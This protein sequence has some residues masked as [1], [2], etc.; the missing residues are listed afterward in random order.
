MPIDMSESRLPGIGTKYLLRPADGGEVTLILHIDGR[1]EL[2]LS[3][4]G[5]SGTRVSL[6][7]EESRQLGAALGGAWERPRIV[8]ELELALGELLIEWTAVPDSSPL[9]GYTL[10]EC[11]FRADTG[12]TV[13]A[14]LREPEPVIAAMPHDRLQ[15]GDTLV[16]VGKAGSYA[17]FRRLLRL[18]LGVSDTSAD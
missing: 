1:R 4:A 3:S 5:A 18:G 2:Y 12:V 14:I 10:A 15:R 11:R 7:D 8:E 13:I 9:I 17:R 6:T 16:T